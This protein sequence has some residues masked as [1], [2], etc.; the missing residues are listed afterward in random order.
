MLSAILELFFP[1]KC[2]GCKKLGTYYCRSCINDIPQGD[3]ICPFCQKPA[4]GGQT[5]PICHRKYGL[6]GLWSLGLYKAGL[7]EAVIQLK[8]RYVQDLSKILIDILVEYWARFD[9]FLIDQFKQDATNWIV[10]PV[11]L[12]QYRKN[13]RGF[14]QTELLAKDLSARLG[15]KY[16][17]VLKRLHNTKPQA[18]LSGYERRR[19]LKN[20][21]E[22]IVN[23]QS[24]RPAG[25]CKLKI[26]N[27]NI[28][29]VDD[30]WTTGSTLKECCYVLKKAG[31][32]QVWGLTMAR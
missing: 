8:Y 20:V 26:E 29:L 5:H 10:V 3:L 28:L 14:N 21:F 27:S 19:N 17:P 4:V 18:K 25:L 9:P 12:H 23:K 22:V 13:W 15:L 32:K 31:A 6:D 2:V 16:A 30:V 24:L 7:R 1:K 11:P